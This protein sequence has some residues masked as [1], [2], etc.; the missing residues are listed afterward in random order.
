MDNEVSRKSRVICVPVVDNDA[1]LEG[2]DNSGLHIPDKVTTETVMPGHSESKPG[3][4][5]T[6]SGRLVKPP[7]RLNL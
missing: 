4:V 1:S 2:G 6:R 5:V 3:E 7:N